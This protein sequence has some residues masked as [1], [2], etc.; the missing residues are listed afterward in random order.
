M[1][2]L[3]FKNC[4]ICGT[5]YQPTGS[6]SKYC[7]T[8]K[9][10]QNKIIGKEAIKRWAYKTGKLN[11]KGSG[12]ATGRGKDNHMYTYGVANFRQFAQ[13]RKDTVGLC[14][15]CAKDLKQATHYEW[16]GHHIDH[17]RKNNDISNLKLMCKSCHQKEHQCWKAFEGVTTISKESRVDNNSKR[18]ASEMSDDIVCSVQEYTANTRLIYGGSAYSYSVD[19]DFAEVG[20]NQK[21]WQAVI[22]EYYNKYRGLAKWHTHIVQTAIATGQLVMP[23]GRV[24]TY[25]PKPNYRGELVWPETTI[26]NYPVQGTGAD[27]MSIIRVDFARQFKRSI[28][29]V[30]VSTVHD[31][32]VVDI[33]S[34]E[35]QKVVDLFNKVYEDMPKNFYKLFGKEYN[36]PIFNEISVGRN[37]KDLQEI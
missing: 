15:V 19:A 36:L 13:E 26:K 23:T 11:G 33:E 31:S 34:S 21:Q 37:M 22:D 2:E 8:C 1:R 4:V 25:A 12:S 24:Y 27:I 6:C 10:I 3:K 18:L 32:I 20:Y 16:V 35:Q 7:T 30:L 14:E 9:P 5:T 29:G 28:K 17:N